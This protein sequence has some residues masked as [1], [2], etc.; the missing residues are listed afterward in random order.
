MGHMLQRLGYKV[1]GCTEPEKALETF[2]S[3][4]DEFD[5]VVTDLSMRGMSGI[6][7]ARELLQIRPGI[8][9]LIASGYIRPADMK[10]SAV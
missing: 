5:V 8:P 9:I 6:D 4:S 2:R 1:T 10:Q 7:F 3:R